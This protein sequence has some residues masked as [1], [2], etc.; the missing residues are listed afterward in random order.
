MKQVLQYQNDITYLAIGLLFI[1]AVS[2]CL[3][4]MFFVQLSEVK[5]A[6]STCASFGSYGEA[7]QAYNAGN[8]RLDHNHNGYPCESLLK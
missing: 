1:L 8:R 7:L 5:V 4:F 6:K 2:V 3:D